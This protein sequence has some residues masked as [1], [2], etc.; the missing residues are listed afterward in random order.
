MPFTTFTDD[1]QP[2]N[3]LTEA[4]RAYSN[5][6]KTEVRSLAIPVRA[7]AGRHR[8]R[9]G[10]VP[11]RAPASGT[12]CKARSWTA[13]PPNGTTTRDR[14][15]CIRKR[16]SSTQRADAI[17]LVKKRLDTGTITPMLRIRSVSMR[18]HE[19]RCRT[20]G[21]YESF[22]ATRDRSERHRIERVRHTGSDIRHGTDRARIGADH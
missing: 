12:R 2:D 6:G 20:L 10:R 11:H 7:V 19:I 13:G 15:S 22:P 3:P 8:L 21:R 16:R 5:D 14:L 17:R 4:A 18:R 9:A 1:Y